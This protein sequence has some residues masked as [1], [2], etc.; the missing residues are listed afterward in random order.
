MWQLHF[1]PSE[2][3]V[4]SMRISL[5]SSA[6]SRLPL[7]FASTKSFSAS[8]LRAEGSSWPFKKR[9]YLVLKFLKASSMAISKIKRAFS[10][11]CFCRLAGLAKVIDG[12]LAKVDRYLN[13]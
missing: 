13:I 1:I 2:D 9:S 11:K 4:S 3:I 12:V 5:S 7:A 8:L 6:M 10:F